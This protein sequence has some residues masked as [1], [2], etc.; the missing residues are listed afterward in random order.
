MKKTQLHTKLTVLN[1]ATNIGNSSNMVPVPMSD[2]HLLYWRLL[3][4]QHLRQVTDVLSVITFARI[5]QN[6]SR[7]VQTTHHSSMYVKK[8]IKNVITI[9]NQLWS[10]PTK[11]TQET[12][13]FTKQQ[14]K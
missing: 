4:F 6:T 3:F 11:L 7:Y 13:N 2:Y 1:L 9:Y 5:H 8:R 12:E 10:I 14:I